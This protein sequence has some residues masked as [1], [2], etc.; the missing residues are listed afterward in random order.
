MYYINTYKIRA[1]NSLQAYYN[2][3]EHLSTTYRFAEDC[4]YKYIFERLKNHTFQLRHKFNVPNFNFNLTYFL[5]EYNSFYLLK[6]N[7]T[8]TTSSGF[9][10]AKYGWIS[11][12]LARL[13]IAVAIELFCPS[14]WQNNLFFDSMNK[15]VGLQ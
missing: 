4:E 13:L 2:D 3:K 14:V 9:W 7:R 12:I 15:G 6:F 5:F 10:S 11:W 1:R 8:V